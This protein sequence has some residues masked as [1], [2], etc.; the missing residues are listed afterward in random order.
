M[1]SVTS[2][3]V[4]DFTTAI[5]DVIS[6]VASSSST[7]SASDGGGGSSTYQLVLIV[8]FVTVGI[9]FILVIVS[10][11]SK[12]YVMTSLSASPSFSSL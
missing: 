3:G 8:V 2:P 9:A 7:A 4:S 11:A 10:D 6:S 5:Y 1:E 12:P